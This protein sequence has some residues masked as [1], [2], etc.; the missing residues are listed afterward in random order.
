[1]NVTYMHEILAV[2]IVNVQALLC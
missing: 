1:M 2:R